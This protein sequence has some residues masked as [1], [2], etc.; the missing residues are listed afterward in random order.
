MRK[1][2]FVS[3]LWCEENGKGNVAFIGRKEG[4]DKGE[5]KNNKITKRKIIKMKNKKNSRSDGKQLEP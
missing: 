5:E 1:R 3:P 4:R 2:E